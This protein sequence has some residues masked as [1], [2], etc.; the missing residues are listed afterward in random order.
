MDVLSRVVADMRPAAVILAAT[1]L[2][3]THS[4]A[5]FARCTKQVVVATYS[6]LALM[7]QYPNVP[8]LISEPAPL[9]PKSTL[10]MAILCTTG[11]EMDATTSSTVAANSKKVPM[12]WMKVPTP[13]VNQFFSLIDSSC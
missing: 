7:R 11:A 8:K 10:K 2:V 4:S 3:R 9:L 6:L 5:W 1:M 12:W 13:M